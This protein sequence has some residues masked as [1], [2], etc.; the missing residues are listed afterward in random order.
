MK[1]I[2]TESQIKNIM[3]NY[4]DSSDYIVLGGEDIGEIVLLRKGTKD[5]HDYLYTFDDKR[6]MVEET[7]LSAVSSLFDINLEDSLEYLGE[8][9]EDRYGLE[10]DEIINWFD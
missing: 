5:H 1:Y 8:W 10:V 7:I 4:L 3:W 2:I 6:L 9:F